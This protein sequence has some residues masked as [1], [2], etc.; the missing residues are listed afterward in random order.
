MQLHQ[1]TKRDQSGFSVIEVLLVVLVVAALAATGF[2][3][4]QRHKSTSAK[5]T[6]STSSSQTTTK[7]AVAA[8][9]YLTIKE[10]GG[11]LPLS[12][13][14]SDAYYTPSI[15]SSKGPDGQPNTLLLGKK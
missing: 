13:A 9:Q 6:A 5:I 4:Y 2:V 3:V 14:I 12:S 11:K 7:P 1:P 15:G 10:R 8:T